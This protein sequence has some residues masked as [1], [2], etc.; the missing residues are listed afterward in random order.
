MNAAAASRAVIDDAA[1]HATDAITDTHSAVRAANGHSRRGGSK[2]VSTRWHDPPMATHTISLTLLDS[3]RELP[4]EELDPSISALSGRPLRRLAV[5]ATVRGEESNDRVTDE[6]D[7]ASQK[8]PLVDADG[9]RWT[10]ATRSLSYSQGGVVF[11]H[12]FEIVE[13]ENTQ[14]ERIVVDGLDLAVDRWGGRLPRDEGGRLVVDVLT[15]CTDDQHRALER[16]I[17]HEEYLRYF[18]VLFPGLRDEPL[19]MRFGRCLWEDSGAGRVRHLFTLVGELTADDADDADDQA[20]LGIN[21]P[22]VSRLREAVVRQQHQL[23]ALIAELRAANVL[24]AAAMDR[25]AAV[26]RPS[27][28]DSRRQFE[29]ADRLEAF[30]HGPDLNEPGAPESPAG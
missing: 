5:E 27:S 14:L 3:S 19:Q 28:F 8:T 25:I 24:G 7:R 20:G 16:L 6:L 13:Q 22:E 11:T 21:E 26:L 9:S 4:A 18:P 23:D 2:S 17:T 1:G 30:F 12:H 10:V 15:T 29:R